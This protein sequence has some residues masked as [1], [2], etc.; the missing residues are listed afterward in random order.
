METLEIRLHAGG[1]AVDHIMLA[2]TQSA[3]SLAATSAT[4]PIPI[5]FE[6]LA[7]IV[8]AMSGVLTAREHK[9][10]LIGAI[11]M[12]VLCALGGG[13]IRD[14]I[15]QE[16]NVYILQQPLAIPVTIAAAAATFVFPRIA[17]KPDRLIAVLDIFSVGL[18]AV[19]GADKTHAY[20]YPE[21]TCVMMGFFTAV[22]GGMLRDICL[23]RVP[24]IFKRG[25]LYAIAAIAGAVTYMVLL[26]SVGMWNIAAAA[27]ATAITM[28]V[29]WWSLRYNILSPT[30][31][32]LTR[33]KRAV[34][35]IRRVARP[36]ARPI[37]RMYRKP[38]VAPNE[39]PCQ[40]D[41]DPQK[42]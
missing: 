6:M 11:G 26:E 19:M 7:V 41:E 14:V 35:P 37:R 8:A 15:L 12:A 17:E 32:D 1:A 30:E 33:V 5:A 38:G 22:G 39:D 20:G 40:C 24:A 3:T 2:V 18:F 25:N 21:I 31:V 9:L 29:R 16:G 34:E 10:D 28:L 13:L 36:I 42:K 23:A 4:V 27:I